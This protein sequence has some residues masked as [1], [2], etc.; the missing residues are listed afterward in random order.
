M[1]EKFLAEWSGDPQDPT[2]YTRTRDLQRHYL[3]KSIREQQALLEWLG[4][5]S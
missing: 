3:D 1:A 4:N 2:F 5:L